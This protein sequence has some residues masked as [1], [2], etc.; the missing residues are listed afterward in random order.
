M[1]RI[2]TEDGG[3]R[4]T[5]PT[6]SGC[7]T[8]CWGKQCRACY[9]KKK[10]TNEDHLF[11]L[12]EI[13]SSQNV[14]LNQ[15]NLSPNDDGRLFSNPSFAEGLLTDVEFTATV[16]NFDGENDLA[17][18]NQ[19][20]VQ[21][22]SLIKLVTSIVKRVTA[23]LH[24][25]IEEVRD[26]NKS[27]YEEIE[28]LKAEKAEA[29][30]ASGGAVAP[31]ATVET[32][33]APYKEA[34]LK[35]APMEKS[36]QNQQRYLDQDDAKK[37][38]K[39]II[40]T[41]VEE[42]PLV[43]ADNENADHNENDIDNNAETDDNAD[44]G[45]K[46]VAIV[47]EIFRAAGCEDVAPVRVKRIGTRSKKEGA[48]CRPILVITDSL[49]SKKKILKNKSQLKDQNE[50]Q[51]KSIYIK[52]DQPIAIQREWR[53]LKDRLKTEKDA[54]TNQGVTI[55]IDYKKRELLRNDTV[56]DKFRSPFQKGGPNQ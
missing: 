41:G 43:V 33:L 45:D 32:A 20:P 47:K 14:N 28:A 49:D 34:L 48:R 55:R 19:V 23:P 42:L 51:Y 29:I 38:E 18:D 53:R 46:D 30:E 17:D 2:D 16:E 37:R 3:R 25:E 35:L 44:G 26:T 13:I 10:K 50:E 6:C 24:K 27:L 11:N 15:S 12:Q 36:L 56:I 39:N 5:M 31:V 21:T 1:Q 52:A 22:F 8:H 4:S 40:I 54:P 7:Q 9:E